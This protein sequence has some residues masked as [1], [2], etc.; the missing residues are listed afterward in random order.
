M[1]GR[2]VPSKLVT[3][4]PKAIGV[5]HKNF[6]ISFN[7]LLPANSTGGSSFSP[8]G[9]NRI[10]F[11][12]PSY[13]N[14]FLDNARSYLSFKFDMSASNTILC[15]SMG[16]SALFSRL[17]IRSGPNIIEDIQNLDV[18]NKIL[19]SMG[20]KDESR[21][22]EGI[23]TREYGFDN[24]DTTK[25]V[26]ISAK[27]KTGVEM[28]YIFKHG[29]LAE[30]LKQ[31][32]P[33]HNMNM[34]DGRAYQIELYLNDATRCLMQVGDIPPFGT[35][36]YSLSNVKYNMCLLKADQTIISRLSNT[37]G[38]KIV[39][40]F[41]TYRSTQAT[42]SA[43]STVTQISE[44]CSDLR[45][46]H[47][48]IVSG[49]THPITNL[50]DE[51]P[52]GSAFRGGILD[53]E[54]NVQEYNCQVGNKLIFTEGLQSLTDNNAMMAQVKNA[55]FSKGQMLLETLDFK[56]N[57][58]R[59]SYERSLFS[60]TSSFCYENSDIMSNGISLSSLPLVMKLKLASDT[61]LVGKSLL[62]FAQCGYY[63]VIENGNCKLVDSKDPAD[64]GY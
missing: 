39:I 9:V 49:S 11:S 15:P 25:A 2:V 64:F 48:V 53:V 26:L 30:H 34:A 63:L 55:S 5:S 35:V 38:G 12:V 57:S 62:S 20:D 42:L 14:T 8:N 3:Y 6:D 16:T 60:M 33:L 46:V 54:I 59:P 31:F 7:S 58:I 41:S 47:T 23:Y 52:T 10:L 1:S 21:L 36:G 43:Q 51:Y 37:T 32:I 27:Q 44:T 45:N 22:S 13:Q 28:K 24:V 50:T 17:V 61:A 4:G 29:I 40:P 19:V 56:S 18:L